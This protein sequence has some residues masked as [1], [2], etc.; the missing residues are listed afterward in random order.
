MG[1][2]KDVNSGK[3]VNFKVKLN[4][5]PEGLFDNIRLIRIKYN[6]FTEN[7]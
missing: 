2:N 5:V 6:D 1:N 7:P 3:S 4:D